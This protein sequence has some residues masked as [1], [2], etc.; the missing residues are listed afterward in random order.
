MI[1][2][3]VLENHKSSFGEV[4]KKYGYLMLGSYAISIGIMLL[5]VG[6]ILS[7]QEEIHLLGLLTIVS[8]GVL[9][10]NVIN[11][12][13]YKSFAKEYEGQNTIKTVDHCNEI[14]YKYMLQNEEALKEVRKVRHD[15]NN[16]LVGLLYLLEQEEIEYAKKY[17]KDIHENLQ[18]VQMYYN[19]GHSIVDAMINQKYSNCKE[20][21]IEFKLEKARIEH[22]DI[23][24]Q[25]LCSILGNVLDNAVEGTMQVINR[26]KMIWME[27]Y[28]SKDYLIMNVKNTC[29]G[30]LIGE[31]FE[32]Q[33]DKK[34]HGIGIKSIRDIAKR[35]DGNV[36]LDYK[37][38][39]FTTKVILKNKML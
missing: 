32:T 2:S 18:S 33:K 4:P 22:I 24:P 12:Y 37:E 10:I 6:G 30:E 7:S 35:Y 31:N 38:D 15:L 20:K 19:T 5:V 9:L 3:K 14:Q 21:Q 11:I 28:T 1:I 8:G 26:P 36:L 34:W 13:M 39:I 27:I 23:R 25:D 16:K 29:R 17:V